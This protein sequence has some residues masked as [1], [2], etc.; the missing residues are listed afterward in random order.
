MGRHRRRI[1]L[2]EAAEHVVD[3]RAALR[4]ARARPRSVRARRASGCGAHRSNTGRAPGSRSRSPKGCAETA[5]GR[6]SAPGAPAAAPAPAC[7]GAA[8][9]GGSVRRLRRMPV[10]R[11]RS[12]T[13][14]FRRCRKR[15]GT[16]GLPPRFC[17]R[18]ITTSAQ[19]S[20]WTKSCAVWPMRRSGGARPMRRASGRLRK[21]SVSVLGGHVPSSSP[22]STTRS[23]TRRRAS[24]RPR[25]FRRRWVARGDGLRCLAGPALRR[26]QDSRQSAP[27]TPLDAEHERSSKKPRAPR[28]VASRGR[29]APPPEPPNASTARR[30]WPPRATRST[31]PRPAPAARSRRRP[32]ASRGDH[33]GRE[34]PVA[35]GQ[36]AARTAA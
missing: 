30:W 28:H 21:A 32:A 19:P 35:L 20:A 7:R 33:V 4:R 27:S 31:R 15:E 3:E 2:G 22:P 18:V 6:A 36:A 17:A 10:R 1:R 34:D 12:P 29:G 23:T 24:R 25:I 14:A 8:R 26:R 16:M 5:P 13:K 9:G 11:R